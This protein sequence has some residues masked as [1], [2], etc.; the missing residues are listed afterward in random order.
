MICRSIQYNSC[1]FLNVYK[2][3]LHPRYSKGYLDPAKTC[4]GE[5]DCYL[6]EDEASCTAPSRGVVCENT[7]SVR[8][9]WYPFRYFPYVPPAV[10]CD[11]VWDCVSGEDEWGCEGARSCT[12]SA[13]YLG[14]VPMLQTT[15]WSNISQKNAKY[16]PLK[17]TQSKPARSVYRNN[18]AVCNDTPHT[19]QAVL[20]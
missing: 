4:D 9:G 1:I 11:G 3:P 13:K 16:I 19:L 7:F 20:R 15:P 17:V 5:C 6:C 2:A 18:T 14:N 12:S 10:V 8:V